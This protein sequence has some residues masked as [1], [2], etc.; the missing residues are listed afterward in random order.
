MIEAIIKMVKVIILMIIST[1][2][3]Q[4]TVKDEL[5][6]SIKI[7]LITSMIFY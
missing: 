1:T 7:M 4:I 6:K 2:Y 5:I 3:L